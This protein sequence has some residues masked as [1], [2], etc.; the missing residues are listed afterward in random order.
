MLELIPEHQVAKQARTQAWRQVGALTSNDGLY[1]RNPT[2]NVVHPL[3]NEQRIA[4]E[5][6]ERVASLGQVRREGGG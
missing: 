4:R 6:G 3:M 5:N 1:R 2:L